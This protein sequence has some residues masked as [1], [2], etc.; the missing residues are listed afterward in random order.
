MLGRLALAVPATVSADGD[1]QDDDDAHALA[2]LNALLGGMGEE[3]VSSLPESLRGAQITPRLLY[4]EAASH[5]DPMGRRHGADPIASAFMSACPEELEWSS[6]TADAEEAGRGFRLA[7]GGIYSSAVDLARFVGVLSGRPLPA[8]APGT[9][10]DAS[11]L[12]QTAEMR[13]AANEGAYPGGPEGSDGM[14]ATHD[15]IVHYG[16]GLF[17]TVPADFS[18]RGNPTPEGAREIAYHAGGTPG[19]NAEIAFDVKTGWGAV[20][21]RNYAGGRVDLA[22]VALE[23]AAVAAAAEGAGAGDAKL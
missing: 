7:N 13:A 5:A 4:D 15:R 11:L 19:F 6:S 1:V 17:S 22:R 2:T 23:A 14:R 20:V 9:L 12:A 10:A 3:P 18:G 16:L 21:L 8:N